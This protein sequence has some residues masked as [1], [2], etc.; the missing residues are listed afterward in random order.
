METLTHLDFP[1]SSDVTSEDMDEFIAIRGCITKHWTTSPVSV[2][3]N[4]M[5][6]KLFARVTVETEHEPKLR[7]CVEK[8][9]AEHQW[10]RVQIIIDSLNVDDL[11]PQP[12]R[13]KGPRFSFW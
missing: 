9:K 6:R 12:L 13:M 10:A 8:L 7:E 2:S 4:F 11:V 5:D 3:K 1:G